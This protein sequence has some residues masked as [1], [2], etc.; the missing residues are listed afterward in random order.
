MGDYKR[1]SEQ[2]N[3]MDCPIWGTDDISDEELLKEF[4]AV[5]H[6]A[7][8]L[9]I[10]SP[11]PDE[12]EK[13]WTRIQEERAESKNVPESNQPEH[14]KVIRPRFGW[15]RLAAVGL[16]ACLVAGSGCMVAM[17]TKSYFYREKE[18]K[19]GQNYKV[20]VN[21]TNRVEVN[22]E[23]EAYTLIEQDLGIKVLKLGYIPAGMI[24]NNLTMDEGYSVLEF[25][26]DSQPVYFI[27][28]KSEI[29]TSGS[30]ISDGKLYSTINNKWLQ[31][32]VDIKKEDIENGM[33]RFECQFLYKGAY[34]W[35]F[36]VMDETEFVKVA[37]RI[38]P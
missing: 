22:G 36:G 4:E 1:D 29:A 24:F 33:T 17:G 19:G 35:L 26:Y 12:F 31:L 8:P 25:E 20:L 30:Y 38:Y 7:V 3:S 27:Q 15:K 5:K 2:D 10:P 23:D 11:S 37:Q 13:I 9:P 14:P 18:L 16:I 21:D 28:S 34:Y 32:E 6:M